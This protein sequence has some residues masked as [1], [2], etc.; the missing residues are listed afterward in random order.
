MRV[1]SIA[2]LLM[3]LVAMPAWAVPDTASLFT[4]IKEEQKVADAPRPPTETDNDF[5]RLDAILF[6]APEQW[7]LLT[8]HGRWAGQS[9]DP[10]IDILAVDHGAV[11]MVWHG[12]VMGRRDQIT[13][14]PHQSYHFLTGQVD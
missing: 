9:N 7:V 4:S 11:Q 13:L 12:D 5:L 14:Y 1:A 3:C 8:N 2:L 10:R 6:Y